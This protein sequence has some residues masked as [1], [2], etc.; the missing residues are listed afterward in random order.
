MKVKIYG[1]PI[2]E[3]TVDALAK[4]DAKGIEYEYVNFIEDTEKLA[5][6]L[7][8]RDTEAIYAPV[9]ERGGIGMPL[10]IFEDGTMTLDTDEALA[11]LG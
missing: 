9:K 2:C 8:I 10:F 4:L 5:E 3:D 11:K 7:K 6:F 1:T